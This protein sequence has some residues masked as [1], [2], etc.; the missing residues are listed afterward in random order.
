MNGDG[1]DVNAIVV[2]AKQQWLRDRHQL[3]RG[4]A[5]PPLDPPAGYIEAFAY[6][7]RFERLERRVV[8]LEDAIDELRA[9]RYVAVHAQRGGSATYPVVE[10]DQ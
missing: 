6:N 5:T 4:T 8:E 2:R 1:A 7:E 9:K 10:V 3:T